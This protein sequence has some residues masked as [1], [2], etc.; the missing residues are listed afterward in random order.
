MNYDMNHSASKD[1]DLKGEKIVSHNVE[2]F[3]LIITV[4]KA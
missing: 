1:Q 3:R 2:V 4:S